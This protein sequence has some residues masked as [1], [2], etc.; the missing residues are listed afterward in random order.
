MDAVG[1]VDGR[2]AALHGHHIALGGKDQ[3]FLAEKIGLQRVDKLLTVP[4]V[5]LPVQNLPQPVELGV[6]VALGAAALLV[7][8]VG[9]HAVLGNAVHLPRAN[10]NF[11]GE[12]HFPSADHRGVQALVHVPLGYADVVLEAARN[13]VPQGVDD[14][15][16]RVA[17]LHRVHQH[18]HGDQIVDL[19]EG[20]ALSVHFFV[21]GVK[22]LG[23]PIHL[24][25]NVLLVQLLRQLG[26]DPADAF[27]PLHPALAH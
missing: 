8:P 11:K 19:V 27:L 10:L 21:D 17:V 22:M 2:C 24:V 25:M 5:P 18:P 13:L 4:G 23:P 12:G 3:H 26:N 15:Q 9:G 16:H 6:H 14:A 1:K 7:A 20:L